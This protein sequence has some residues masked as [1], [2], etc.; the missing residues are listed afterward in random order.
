MNAWMISYSFYE[1]DYRVRR[2]AEALAQPGNTVEV[3]ALRK[4]GL[5]P[6]ETIRDVLLH[7]V[8]RRHCNERSPITFFLRILLF[9]VRVAWIVSVRSLRARPDVIHV[10]NV[11]D[12]LIFTCI[13]PKLLGTKVIL[14]IHDILPEFYC[15]K[16]GISMKHPLAKAL[17]WIEYL[18]THF[19]DH[20]IVANDIWREKIIQRAR[21]SEEHCTTILNYPD[22]VFFQPGRSQTSERDE[23]RIIYPGTISHLHGTDVAIRAM[24]EVGKSLPHARLDLYS[25]RTEGSPYFD[26]INALVD[27]LGVRNH[28][29]FH[30]AVPHEQMSE[31]LHE[32]DVGIVPKRKG[33]FAS[34]AFSTKIMEFMAAGVPVIASR[35]TIDEYY[36][37]DTILCFFEPDNPEDLARCLIELHSDSKQRERMASRA[38][39]FMAD[40]K[41]EQKKSIYYAIV[42]NLLGFPVRD[43]VPQRESAGV[44]P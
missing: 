25:S 23:F 27:E 3:F 18:S 12:F 42:S 22:E 17:R 1:I 5:P 19:A 37:D 10:H 32:A 16:F 6:T 43:F 11:P 36:F 38:C 31:L 14:D 9:F 7:R 24:S 20:V 29:V 39:D 21:I 26:A 35:T 44:K 34:E 4:D 41:W 8:Q 2:Y 28:V 40:K 30:P 13:I 15:Q 33:V